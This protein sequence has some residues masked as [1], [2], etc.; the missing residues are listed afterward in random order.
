MKSR[1]LTIFIVVLAL[2]FGSL[3]VAGAQDT[4]QITFWT[5]EVQPE[6]VERQQDIIA[7]FEEANPGVE[8]ELVVADENL[9]DQLM[10][11]NVAAGTPPD[12]VLHPLQLS[13]KWYS[14]GLLDADF[15]TQ[16]IEALDSST[17]AAGALGLL[18]RPDGE[19][20]IAVPAD[21]WGQMLVYRSDLFE[22][23][24]LAA[25]DSYD[26]IMTAAE[27]LHDSDAGFTAFCG[28]NSASQVFTWQVFEHVALA[29][30]A[31][32]VDAD[33]NITFNSPEMVEA[34]QFY[35]DVMNNYGPSESDWYWLQTRAEYLAG[36]CGM[37]MWS[38][39][40]L[41]EMAGLRDSVL[42][43]C[44]ECADNPAYIA[45]NSNFVAAITGYSADS[46]AAW[47][48][49]TSIG[50]APGASAEAQ[51]FVEFWFS[52]AYLDTL[53][54]AAEGKFPMRAGT[55]DN[56]TQ[57]IDGWGALEVGVDTRAPLSD[58]YDSED[59]STI[60]GGSA[61]YTR[62]G[63]D[64]GQSVLASAVGAQFFIQENLVAVLNGDLSAEE[65]AE[66]IQI[67]IEDL[68]FE[69]EEE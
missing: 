7:A 10:T 4:V 37:T 64:V 5:T 65:A 59:L 11:L 54:I 43:T 58:F 34:I 20:W 52:D 39:F 2:L 14:E 18:S 30:G 42:P 67:L 3:A 8:V 61:G 22:A 66:E 49:V 29:N 48:S 38:P 45:Q 6:R 24:G 21:G 50:L 33:G 56:P 44:P 28:A 68:Q 51:A 17:F 46:P 15:A 25:P 16:I 9:M 19:G 13:A 31:T 69:L 55:P 40:I 36:N 47:G 32:F 1:K 57:F 26:N 60:V 63:F 12:V 62:M 35:A 41:D 27:A 23:A 53:A